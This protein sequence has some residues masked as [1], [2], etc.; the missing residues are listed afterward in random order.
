M[1]D[2]RSQHRPPEAVK[3]MYTMSTMVAM[4]VHA[5]A[6]LSAVVA[7]ASAL[8]NPGNAPRLGSGH[9]RPPILPRAVRALRWKPD[10]LFSLVWCSPRLLIV[11]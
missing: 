9:I 6:L 2:Y 11:G 10:R 4:L 5:V 3:Q 7:F 8:R 1:P